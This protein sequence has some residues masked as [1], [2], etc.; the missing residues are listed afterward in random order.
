MQS[1][2]IR[3]MFVEIGK[4]NASTVLQGTVISTEPLKIQIANDSKLVISELVTVVP[5]HLTDYE[6]TADIECDAAATIDSTTTVSAGHTHKLDSFKVINAKI[7]IHNAL[8]K[9]DILDILALNGGKKY[10]I[11]D[12]VKK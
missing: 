7:T 9:G 2:S 8:K 12:R 10:Y 11:L 3:G 6:T 4:T 5:W 1:T